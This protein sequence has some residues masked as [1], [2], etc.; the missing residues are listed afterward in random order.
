MDI[1][2]TGG[3]ASIEEMDLDDADDEAL[4]QPSGSAWSSALIP[5]TI[6]RPWQVPVEGMQERV[7][8]DPRD[9]AALQLAT[10]IRHRG[11]HAA[12]CELPA[13]Q[14][15]SIHGDLDPRAVRPRLP[16]ISLAGGNQEINRSQSTLKAV[17]RYGLRSE[18]LMG[19]R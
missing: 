2:G 17:G 19:S 7:D 12:S 8:E 4:M 5:R 14:T 13:S 3:E 11:A 9:D 15:A 1:A 6:R 10:A 18:S 16:A